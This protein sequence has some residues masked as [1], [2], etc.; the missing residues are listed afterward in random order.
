[1]APAGRAIEESTR[2]LRSIPT[3]KRIPK[4]QT[5]ATIIQRSDLEEELP[6]VELCAMMLTHP[7]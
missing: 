7:R 3:P 6:S 2:E 1:L 4:A 5:N